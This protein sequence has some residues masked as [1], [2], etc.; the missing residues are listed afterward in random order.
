[1]RKALVAGAS[2]LVL[3]LM[4]TIIPL[5]AES[6]EVVESTIWG[7][8]YDAESEEPLSD[9]RVRLFANVG[10]QGYRTGEDGRYEFT[11]NVARTEAFDIVAQKESYY[12]QWKSGEI[13]RGET[14]QIDFML[15]PKAA[16]IYGYVT[17][18][19]TGEPVQS[20]AVQL[21]STDYDGE[22]EYTWTDEEGYYSMYARVGNYKLLS[23]ADGYEIYQSEEFYLEEEQVLEMN[24]SLVQI[25]TGVFGQVTSNEDGPLSGAYIR[26]YD[27]E[28]SYYSYTFS[29]EEGNYELRA[30]PGEYI[31][32]VSAED[33][34][35]YDDTIVIE[36]D[37]M[38]EYDIVMNKITVT[39]VLR[40][41][42]DFI[43]E[44]LGGIF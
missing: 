25:V 17:D 40:F 42:V 39:G 10:G 32:E 4:L 29:D 22:D 26:M 1:M 12:D 5:A 6:Q 19:A 9:A 11:I 14:I 37:G 34:F 13:G 20:A 33:H 3:S 18:S 8:V 35:D 28:F 36:E 38:L 31:I 27:Q 41:I 44:L 15:E 30:P 16:M 24:I 43:R 7:Y 2:L 21:Y 23:G